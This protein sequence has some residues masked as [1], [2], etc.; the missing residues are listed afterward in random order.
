M[1]IDIHMHVLHPLMQNTDELWVAEI[2]MN[3]SFH[4][5]VVNDNKGQNCENKYC[6]ILP[7]RSIVDPTNNLT[8]LEVRIC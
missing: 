2:L 7:Y 8:S 6:A 3:S 5:S 4:D 1:D